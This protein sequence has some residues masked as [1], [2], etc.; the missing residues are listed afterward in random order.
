MDRAQFEGAGRPH[1]FIPVAFNLRQCYTSP[2]QF[3]QCTVMGIFVYPP[4]YGLTGIRQPGR[5]L[6]PQ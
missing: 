5:K 1:H 6:L 2:S 3:I 4:E